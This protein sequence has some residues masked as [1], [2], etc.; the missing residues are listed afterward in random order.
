MFTQI[1]HNVTLLISLVAF[2]TLTIRFRN[3]YPRWNRL[4]SGLM[5]GGIS[6][7]GMMSPFH[8]APGIIFDGRSIILTLAGLFGGGIVSA[9]SILMAGA[10]R[11]WLGGAGMWAGLGTIWCCTMLGLLF[12]RIV[13]NEPFRLNALQLFGIGTATHIT[14]LGCQLL[15][16]WPVGLA[17]I[18]RMWLPVLLIMP[19]A[20]AAMGRLLTIAEQA[21]FSE[22]E[23]RIREKAVQQIAA[24]YKQLF[25]SIGS[26]VA[27]YE[28][29][30]NGNDFIIVD[31][32]ETGQK[33]SRV[34]LQEIR[35]KRVTEVFPGVRNIGLLDVLRRVWESGNSEILPLS[36]YEDDRIMEW[37][38]NHV[39]RLPDGK[40]VA[41]YEDTTEKQQALES[42]F[43]REKEQ[44]AML[45]SMLNAFVLFESVFD[46]EGIFVSYRFVYI[47]RAYE[48]ITGVKL[49]E[50]EGKTVHE[51]WPDTEPEWIE[52]Y[53]RT[54]T[55]GISQ[56]FDLYHGPTKKHYHC[57][58]YRPWESPDRFCVIFEDITELTE[59]RKQVA[60]FFDINID[61]FCIADL[62]GNFIRLNPV[63]ER[64]LGYKT[65]DLEG[66][67]FL[68]L[69]HPDDR[70]ATIRALEQQGQGEEVDG[71][72]NRYRHKDGT[73]RWI[74]WRSRPAG[75]FVYASARDIT[76]QYNARLQLV[77]S[78][79]KFR[80]LFENM[81]EGFAIHEMIFDETGNP[82]DYR[83]L[84]VNPAFERMTGLKADQILGRRVKEALPETED[85][86][87]ERYGEVVKTGESISF[88]APSGALDAH[89]LVTAFRPAPG[90]FAC[91]VTD[92]TQRVRMEEELRK[93]NEA[94][95]LRVRQR[96][97]KLELANREL[98]AFAYSVSHDLKAPLRAIQGF[99][100]IIRERFAEHLPDK[101]QKYF[102]NI[103]EASDHMHI[104]I[105]DLLA[106]SRLGKSAVR[107]ELIQ[108]SPLLREVI[109]SLEA[110]LSRTRANITF[111]DDLPAVEGDRTLI[112]VIF[113]N[114]IENALTY[115]PP[116]RTPDVTIRWEKGTNG[117]LIHVVDNGIGIPPEHHEKIFDIF[118]RLHPQSR[119]PGTGIGLGLVRKA[120]SL[121]NAEVTVDS[122]IDRGAIFTIKFNKS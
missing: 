36:K 92:I 55:T 87:I 33:M 85:Y 30:E 70:K 46:D 117:P 24:Q 62:D 79:E 81:E 84:N 41:L 78:E 76:D 44:A 111:P 28:A 20:T 66:R 52:R 65:R 8:Y 68:D 34:T 59:A 105:E 40:V 107:Q 95:E 80:M 19:A 83:F 54:A 42:L 15:I 1:V 53:G 106:Y 75:K 21:F 88:D 17:V 49:E 115:Q 98:E 86:W 3:N 64:T 102:D 35:G 101:G 96:T 37:V 122:D 29:V 114:L 99:A 10:Y 50:V 12:R 11:V 82:V 119:Y 57:N 121:M 94:L 32:N 71:F 56:T 4:I 63:W 9:I 69:V 60:D 48:E 73:W 104:L 120:A 77:E 47:N 108:L 100:E 118:Q 6:V 103:V 109:A 113:S 89:F 25:N 112:K 5:F 90:R 7:L 45:D 39:Y 13:S 43:A 14:M 93:L 27:V 61:L 31:I 22:Q 116:D 23:I 58:V 38:E 72:I 74:E 2:Y 18:Q 67:P 16:P 97:R 91:T 26:G 110:R 51:I